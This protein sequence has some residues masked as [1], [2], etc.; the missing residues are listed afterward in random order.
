MILIAA[1][2]AATAVHAEITSVQD[3][4][5]SQP[6]TAAMS[7]RPAVGT[8]VS[9]AAVLQSATKAMSPPKEFTGS[10]ES[11]QARPDAGSVVPGAYLM[12]G[13]GITGYVYKSANLW[14]TDFRCNVQTGQ[15]IALQTV[16]VTMK[17]S[18]VG[19]RSHTWQV[20]FFSVD[21]SGP[22]GSVAKV[23][24]FRG[25]YGCGMRPVSGPYLTCYG[26]IPNASPPFGP[27]ELLEKYQQR[28]L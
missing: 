25:G 9:K 8:V 6:F 11:R 20:T 21:E 16:R 12:R 17:Q 10:T 7:E 28:V 5:Y 1:Q 14:P 22:N 2:N 24:S 19:G 23:Y 18:L 13:G 15:C 27:T 4:G 26:T 3:A